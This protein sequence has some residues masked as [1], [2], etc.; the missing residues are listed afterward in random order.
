MGDKIGENLWDYTPNHGCGL[1][2]G[3]DVILPYYK[4]GGESEWPHTQIKPVSL[5]PSSH[6]T[7]L[8]FSQHFGDPKYAAAVPKNKFRHEERD[9]AVLL[10]GGSA[11]PASSSSAEEPEAQVPVV[12]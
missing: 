2:K 10:S 7:L 3:L 12:N 1:K 5:A 8:M 4:E 6:L 11:E 9:F